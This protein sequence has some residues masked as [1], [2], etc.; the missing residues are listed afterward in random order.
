MVHRSLKNTGT[1]LRAEARRGKANNG[2]VHVLFVWYG[3]NRNF[4]VY[5]YIR[6]T[7][8]HDACTVRPCNAHAHLVPPKHPAWPPVSIP[9]SQAREQ[10]WR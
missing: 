4:H 3:L 7:C 8:V 2:T 1:T 6:N 10:W 9:G 5:I